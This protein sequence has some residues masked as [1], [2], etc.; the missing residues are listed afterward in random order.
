MQPTKNGERG[1]DILYEPEPEIVSLPE[2]LVD[3]DC[4]RHHR[5]G[6]C[7]FACV[8]TTTVYVGEE[9]YESLYE[10]EKECPEEES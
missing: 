8:D 5:D 4:T 6:E 7:I 9:K 3:T 1:I 10:Y 2:V